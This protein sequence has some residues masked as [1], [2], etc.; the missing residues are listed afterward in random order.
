[1]QL[2][3]H[4]SL[5]RANLACTKIPLVLVSNVQG[6]PSVSGFCLGFGL[7]LRF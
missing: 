1:M 5:P 6:L 4:V 7:G 3:K 2:A